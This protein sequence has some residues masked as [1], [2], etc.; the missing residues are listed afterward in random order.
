MYII[1]YE[2]L[3]FEKAAIL[4]FGRKTDISKSPDYEW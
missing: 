3:T 4:T 1:S 2:L